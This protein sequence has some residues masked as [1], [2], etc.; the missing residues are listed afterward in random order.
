MRYTRSQDGVERTTVRLSF[1]FTRGEM[2]LIRRLAREADADWRA[3]LESH[4]SL[5]IEGEMDAGDPDCTERT[6]ANGPK[7]PAAKKRRRKR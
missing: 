5:G 2:A 7:E 3:W 1:R 4:A 6:A